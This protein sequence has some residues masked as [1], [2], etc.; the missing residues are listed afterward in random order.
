MRMRASK[1]NC[2]NDSDQQVP[3]AV[4]ATSRSHPRHRA[5]RLQ[6]TP[7]PR[8]QTT[9]NTGTAHTDYTTTNITE[10]RKMSQAKHSLIANA[11]DMDRAGG[12]GGGGGRDSQ[13]IR[14]GIAY[15]Y[16]TCV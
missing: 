4:A 11:A 9:T 10:P 13:E 7:A 2:K 16:T 6:P 5:H 8:T 1:N 3:P 14:P 12:G 15:T